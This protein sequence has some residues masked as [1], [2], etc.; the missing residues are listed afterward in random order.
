MELLKNAKSP[1]FWKKVRESEVYRGHRENLFA[2]WKEKCQKPIEVITYSDFRRFFADG[3]RAEYEAKYF[4]RR[5]SANA[6]A[7]LALIYPEEEKYLL[8][9]MDELYTICDEYTWCLPAHQPNLEE[10]FPANLDLFACETSFMLA[11]IDTILAHRLEPLIRNRIR[12]EIERRILPSFDQKIWHWEKQKENWNAVCTSSVACTVMLLYPELFPK[13]KERFLAAAENYL[14]G[15]ASDGICPEGLGYW[16]YGFGFF[17]MYADMIRTFTN[18]EIDY[19]ARPHVKN[20]A[21]FMQK[22]T[23]SGSTVVSFSDGGRKEKSFLS[24]LHYLKKEYPNDIALPDTDALMLHDNCARFGMHLRS[25][26]WFLEEYA[27]GE[28][29]NVSAEYFAENAEWFIRKNAFYGFAAKGGHNREPHNHNDVG[30][31]ILA[32]DGRQVISD[33]GAGVYTRQYF[34]AETRYDH[35]HCSSRGHNVPMIGGELQKFGEEYRARDFKYE[36][37]M[38]SMDIVDAYGLANLKSLVRS[39]SFTDRT[40]TLTDKYDLTDDVDLTERLVTLEKPTLASDGKIEADGVVLAYDPAVCTVS[41]GEERV[42]TKVTDREEII[43][44]VDFALK[45]GVKTFVLT[46]TV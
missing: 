25:F 26:C 9:L 28:K 15:F 46:M 37:G 17:T 20:I 44:T 1:E 19:F 24:L 21:V 11:E 34:K 5:L 6:C 31:F 18:G 32:R 36:N 4:G 38:L 27:H 7:L 14:S 45:K 16:N 10:N 12:A 35:F 2:L 29:Q 22:C 30:T 42:P 33:V 8:R 43:Y 39:F 13:Y 3:N 40:V 41:I 23:L